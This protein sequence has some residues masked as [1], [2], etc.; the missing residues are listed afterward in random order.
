MVFFIFSM[1]DTR[2]GTRVFRREFVNSA[3]P[4]SL[5][6]G[7]DEAAVWSGYERFWNQDEESGDAVTVLKVVRLPREKKRKTDNWGIET[8]PDGRVWKKRK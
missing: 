6:G 3:H 5:F 1:C 2:E 4:D 7:L 8:S